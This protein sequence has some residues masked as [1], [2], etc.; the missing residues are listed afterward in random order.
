[1]SIAVKN[2]NELQLH[3]LQFFSEVEVSEQETQDIKNMVS[4]YYFEKAEA[5][6]SKAI[7]DK[8]IDIEALEKNQ[9]LHFRA[10][11]KS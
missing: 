3:F 9:N 7:A 8:N 11:S 10:K 6:I 2:L 5:A 4:N 1:M